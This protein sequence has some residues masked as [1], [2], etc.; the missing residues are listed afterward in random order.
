M[1][2]ISGT[3]DVAFLKPVE[4]FNS[5][6]RHEE[7]L[8]VSFITAHCIFLNTERRRIRAGTLT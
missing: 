8:E 1:N 4:G 5:I 2:C 7:I 3:S 6:E